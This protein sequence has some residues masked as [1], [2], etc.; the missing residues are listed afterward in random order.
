M[1]GHMVSARGCGGSEGHRLELPLD[2][3]PR[4][5]IRQKG[6]LAA[7]DRPK[8]GRIILGTVDAQEQADVIREIAAK[9]IRI[10]G[11]HAL[12]EARPGP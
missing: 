10:V 5:S 1:A 3:W 7:G 8:A 9:G 2:R 6:C 12:G 11:W 4:H